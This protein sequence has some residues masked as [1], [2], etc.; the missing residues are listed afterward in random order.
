MR[1]Y[2]TVLIFVITA[3]A[4]QAMS[5]EKQYSIS[6]GL[7]PI[8]NGLGIGFRTPLNKMNQYISLGCQ[9]LGYG[10]HSGWLYRCG[11]GY[12]VVANLTKSK[13][14]SLGLNVDILYNGMSQESGMEYLAGI[15]YTYFFNAA[16]SEGWNMQIGPGVSYFHSNFTPVSF[17]GV[18]YQY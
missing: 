14:H 2:L 13:Q 10:S 17:F 11:V 12:S 8:Y 1:I 15:F 6:V 3:Y 9:S 5:K 4:S 18:G 7:G 16:D